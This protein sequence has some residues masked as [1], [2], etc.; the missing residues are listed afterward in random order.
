MHPLDR[1]D[2]INPALPVPEPIQIRWIA[3]KLLNL[4]LA[5]ENQADATIILNACYDLIDLANEL[6]Q[7]NSP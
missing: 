2:D 4:T 7:H 5:T 1:T 3:Y 6:L